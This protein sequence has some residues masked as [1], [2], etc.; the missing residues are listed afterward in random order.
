MV[1]NMQLAACSLQLHLPRG[2][3][4]QARFSALMLSSLNDGRRF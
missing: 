2:I 4:D 1:L 3:E